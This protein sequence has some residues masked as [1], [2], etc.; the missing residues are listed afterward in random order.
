MSRQRVTIAGAGDA[1]TAC[2]RRLAERDDLDVVVVDQAEDAARGRALDLNHGAALAGFEPRVTGTDSYADAAG[3][4]ICVIAVGRG[5]AAAASDDR[6]LKANADAVAAA[7]GEIAEHAP[8][9]IVIVVADP[10]EAMCHAALDA[11]GFSRQRVIGMGGVLDTARLRS[12]LALELGVSVRDVTGLVLGGRG[13]LMVPLVAE[14]TAAGVPVG[15]I[16]DSARLDEVVRRTRDGGAEVER[17][18]GAPG[19]Y[20]AAAAVGEMVDSIAGDR[21]RV[22]PCAALCQ[23]EYG[24]RDVY[25]GVPCTLGASGIERLVEIE[26]DPADME[27]LQR[28]AS[29]IR[30]QVAALAKLRGG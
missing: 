9:A 24:I 22:L 20:A 25:L 19:G 27:A 6:S 4:A 5:G 12:L 23:G 15:R 16:A 1:A 10:L 14:A 11:S 17:L 2:A 29:A 3:S 26:L 28:A 8:D 30:E 18:L 7:A 21:A 13:E